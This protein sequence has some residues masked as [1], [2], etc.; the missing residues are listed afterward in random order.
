MIR[1]IRTELRRSNAIGLAVLLLV[2]AALLIA[3]MAHLWYRQWL[4]FSYAQASALFL[5]VP[6]ALA[7]GAMLGRREKRSKTTELMDS[8]G[9]PRW[10][11]LTPVAAALAVAVTAVQLLTL[12][13]GAVLIGV[14][15]SFI[16]A[17]GALPALVDII[18]LTGA[19]VLGLAAGRAWSAPLVPPALATLALI[20]QLVADSTGE[21]SKLRNLSLNL[22]PPGFAWEA[23]TAQALLGRLALGV[24]LLTGGVLLGVGASWLSRVAGIAALATGLMLAA[25]ITPTWLGHRYG[26]DPA[27]QRLVCADGTPQV[28]LT[29]ANAYAL[30]AAAPAARR[31]LALLA[32][33]PDAPTRAVEWRADAPSTFDSAQFRG[34]TPELEP[35]TVMFRFEPGDRMVS[36]GDLF[37]LAPP[38]PAGLTANIV[39]GAGT[40]MNGCRLGD[41]VALGAAGAWLMGVDVL[42]LTDD[43]FTYDET[44]RADIAATV[45]A[46]RQ[47][48]EREQVRR[49]TALRDAANACRTGDLRTILTGGPAA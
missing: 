43:Q 10:Q 33:L 36:T 22:E 13:I 31:A 3:A 8:T 5:L 27:A 46:L 15:G 42:P 30:P 4:G 23:F 12:G 9:R 39:N 16:T 28:C 18:L 44:V 20:A 2:V 41:P 37:N 21:G 25:A 48:P 32:K 17:G 1:V 14:T 6:L 38:D 45:R 47:L 26:V 19:V 35:G 49:V 24:G 7:G 40:T 34:D 11:K 29:A